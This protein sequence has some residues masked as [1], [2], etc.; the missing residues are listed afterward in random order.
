MRKAFWT[1]VSF[2]VL[3]SFSS[4]SR[5]LTPELNAEDLVF[6]FQCKADVDCAGQKTSCILNRSSPETVRVQIVSGE[7]NGLTYFW[8][9][10]R[11]SVSF[12]GLTA[13]SEECVLPKASFALLLKQTLDSAS[14]A[15]SLVKMHGGEFSGSS[16]GY[17]FTLTADRATGTL[18]TL[19][20]PKYGLTVDLYDYSASGA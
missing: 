8:N 7:M 9:G 4:C 15:G 2:L 10:D 17:D 1:L 5:A 6:T 11:F 18:R 20:I 14:A 16:A 12:G 3:F 13:E 19:K